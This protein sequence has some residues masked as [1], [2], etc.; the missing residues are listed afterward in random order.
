MLYIHLE[1]EMEEL[2]GNLQGWY[3]SSVVMILIY[4]VQRTKKC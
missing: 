3:V 2:K 1:K 4:H